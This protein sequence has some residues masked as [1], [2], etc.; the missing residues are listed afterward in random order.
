MPKTF[1][2]VALGPRGWPETAVERLVRQFD[3][4]VG[5][6]VIAGNGHP[7]FTRLADSLPR[8]RAVRSEP[9]GEW[10]SVQ[11]CEVWIGSGP[12]FIASG[13]NVFTDDDIDA[14]TRFCASREDCVVAVAPATDTRQLTVVDV[15]EGK[16]LDL[17]EKPADGRAGAAKAGLYYFGRA[18]VAAAMAF[19]PRVDR[20][21]ERSMTELLLGLL[22][23]G[24]EVRVYP[25]RGGFHDVGTVEGLAGALDDEALSPPYDGMSRTRK[26]QAP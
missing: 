22:S 15:V 13:D 4:T 21:G 16:A 11:D 12:L 2:P 17:I 1:L 14:F 9:F 10:S 20:F 25:L 7:W 18:T 23:H 24:T 8:L 5:G 26:G 3:D 6:T 19:E